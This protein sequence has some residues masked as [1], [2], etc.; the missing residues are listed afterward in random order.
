MKEKILELATSQIKRGG[1][2]EL[3]FANI[4]RELNI[5]RANIHHHYS[6]KEKLAE[7]VVLHYM[8]MRESELGEMI[9]SAGGDFLK[10]IAGFEEKMWDSVEQNEFGVCACSPFMTDSE[11]VPEKLKEMSFGFYNQVFTGITGLVTEAQKTG[12]IKTDR[13]AEDISNEF[14]IMIIGYMTVLSGE[15]LKT[16]YHVKGLKGALVRWAE[17]L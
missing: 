16:A 7:A 13:P 14:R 15:E 10:V 9:E 2:G 1:Y 11:R 12:K 8:A 17:N 3:S 5:S 4:A 6:S